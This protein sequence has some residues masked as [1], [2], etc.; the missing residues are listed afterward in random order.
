MAMACSAVII[1]ATL[2]TALLRLLDTSAAGGS[3][4]AAAGADRLD[5]AAL[6]GAIVEASDTLPVG[7][8]I[9]VEASEVTPVGPF[10]DRT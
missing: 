1:L 6:L 10:F 8:G 3:A 5:G 2:V 9:M 7:F 4:G